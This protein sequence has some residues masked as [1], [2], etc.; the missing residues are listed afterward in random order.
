[1]SAANAEAL[2]RDKNSYSS[3]TPDVQLMYEHIEPRLAPRSISDLLAQERSSEQWNKIRSLPTH[4]AWTT[5]PVLK[6]PEMHLDMDAATS[7]HASALMV[8]DERAANC[9]GCLPCNLL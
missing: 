6:M 2:V 4:Q 7:A 3:K 1:M 9:C 8:T 5:P